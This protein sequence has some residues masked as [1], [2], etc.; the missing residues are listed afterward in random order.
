MLYLA[1]L[2]KLS[3]F[4]LP[5]LLTLINAKNK[6]EKNNLLLFFRNSLDILKSF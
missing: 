6:Q 2:S 5:D 4:K 1:K 3:V